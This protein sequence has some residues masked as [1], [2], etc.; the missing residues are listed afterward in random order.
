MPGLIQRF[1]DF[2]GG[3]IAASLGAIINPAWNEACQQGNRLTL[4]I[5]F[6]AGTSAGTFVI[7]AAP[8]LRLDGTTS[9][10]ADEWSTLA[11]IAWTAAS[12]WESAS[13]V[14]PHQRIRIKQSVALVGGTAEAFARITT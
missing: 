14:L 10:A 12:K 5:R 7:Q 1:N 13:V 6:G 8:D 2:V 9:T 4:Y 3:T 11:T